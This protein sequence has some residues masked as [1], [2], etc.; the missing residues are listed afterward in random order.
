MI[1]ICC[2]GFRLDDLVAPYDLLLLF[3]QHQ[4]HL[5]SSKTLEYNRLGRPCKHVALATTS[6]ARA[7][8]L[9]SERW[10][11]AEALVMGVVKAGAGWAPEEEMANPVA[12]G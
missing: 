1:A 2:R 5:D 7:Q 6:S 3:L 8:L 4:I 9:C 11:V 10:E 12:E